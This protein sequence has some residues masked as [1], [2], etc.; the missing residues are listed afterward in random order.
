MYREWY[1]DLESGHRT[2]TYSWLPSSVPRDFHSPSLP[3]PS[4]HRTPGSLSGVQTGDSSPVT[5]NISRSKVSPGDYIVTEIIQVF[6]ALLFNKIIHCFTQPSIWASY[7]RMIK[8]LFFSCEVAALDLIYSISVSN[9]FLN[10]VMQ[11]KCL[12]PVHSVSALIKFHTSISKSVTV[13][14]IGFVHGQTLQVEI[15][16]A[17]I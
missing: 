3:P 4:S 7:L 15:A 13:H 17:C 1:Q 10:L 9:P 16:L 6:E 5:A 14:N 11:L 12:Y 2:L 8:D